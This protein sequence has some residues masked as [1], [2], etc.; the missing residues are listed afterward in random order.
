MTLG[1]PKVIRRYATGYRNDPV[2]TAPGTDLIARLSIIRIR[3]SLQRL[4]VPLGQI[5][6]RFISTLKK[7]HQRIR[8]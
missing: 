5:R 1:R 7:I 3:L 8:G 6:C 2:A 4:A